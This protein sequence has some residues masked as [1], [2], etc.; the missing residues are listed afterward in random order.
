MRSRLLPLVISCLVAMPARGQVCVAPHPSGHLAAL[1]Y[2]VA[3]MATHRQVEAG[4][5]YG[6]RLTAPTW[7]G[8]GNSLLLDASWHN[9]RLDAPDG[10]IDDRASLRAATSATVITSLFTHLTVCA[11]LGAGWYLANGE[12]APSRFLD[13]PVG[14]G[15]GATLPVGGLVVLPFVMPTAA[16]VAEF[17]RATV[18]TAEIADN[19][20]DLALTYGAALRF[21][22]L[23]V[24]G[25]WR[26]RDQRVQQ[27]PLFRMSAA[28]WF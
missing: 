14:V 9:G 6:R 10:V 5:T 26:M 17:R 7:I 13:V 4:F 21:G 24:R 3:S 20:R 15:L 18:T 2:G 27:A 11:H 16:Y 1:D 19:R 28:V 25:A 22:R 8:H 23:E 12:P